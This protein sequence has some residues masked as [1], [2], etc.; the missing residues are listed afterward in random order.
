VITMSAKARNAIGLILLFAFGVVAGIAITLIIEG[1]M[2][3]KAFA[4]PDTGRRVLA[5]R[6]ARELGLDDEQR[7]DVDEILADTMDELQAIRAETTP[8]VQEA[9]ETLRHRIDEV[10]APEQ[11]ER[12]AEIYDRMH[13]AWERYGQGGRQHRYRGGRGDDEMGREKGQ[14]NGSG[15]RGAGR[16]AGSSG[17]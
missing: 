4:N 12:F 14:G 15:G 5:N 6:F 7:S 1:A 10:L 2:L 9:L 8:L 17:G 16:G 11:R 3:R 13:R